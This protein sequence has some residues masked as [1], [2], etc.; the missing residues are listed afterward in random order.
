MFVFAVAKELWKHRIISGHRP[1][2]VGRELRAMTVIIIILIII[3]DEKGG[4][5][6]A[7]LSLAAG[8]GS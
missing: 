4:T 8:G 1:T 5:R 7:S 3:I 6:K 2:G